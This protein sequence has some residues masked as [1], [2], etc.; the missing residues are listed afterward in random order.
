MLYIVQ[1]KI[2]FIIAFHIVIAEN[3]YSLDKLTHVVKVLFHENSKKPKRPNDAGSRNI[4]LVNGN[5]YLDNM[6]WWTIEE[7]RCGIYKSCS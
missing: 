6:S 4:F 3:Y 5:V 1:I 7:V 2:R